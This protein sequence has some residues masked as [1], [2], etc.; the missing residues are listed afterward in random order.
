[1]IPK[2]YAWNGSRWVC[3]F[4]LGKGCL[5]C[6]PLPPP[7]VLAEQPTEP[8][9]TLTYEETADPTC[10]AFR[11]FKA[12]VGRDAIV[13]AFSPGGGGHE[14]VRANIEREREAIA[15]ERGESV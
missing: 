2:G 7:P 13:K 11:V 4:C 6:P 10:D 9:L 15:R 14:E 5:S 1:V 3:R 12:A 8:L